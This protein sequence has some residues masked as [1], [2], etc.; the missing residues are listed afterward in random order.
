MHC[1]L[2]R[3]K[4]GRFAGTSVPRG[5]CGSAL[6]NAGKLGLGQKG[7]GQLRGGLSRPV[8]KN[9]R[10][11]SGQTQGGQ[12]GHRGELITGGNFPSAWRTWRCTRKSTPAT[13]RKP[14]RSPT[15][16]PATSSYPEPPDT[17]FVAYFGHLMGYDAGYYGYAWADAIAADMA[18]V[19]EKAPDGFFDRD[20]GHAPAPG[21]LRARAVRAT[22]KSPS[23]NSWAARNP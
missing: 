5:F 1:I 18:T 4:Y 3:A 7:P 12:T 21:D 15:K 6:A 11:N 19:F 16:S 2:T 8:Q 10:R 14:S 17:A 22:C 23:R 13:S 9:S 20:A